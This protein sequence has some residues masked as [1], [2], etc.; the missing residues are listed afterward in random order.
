MAPSGRYWEDLSRY[1]LAEI[2][3]LDALWRS[4]A[5]DL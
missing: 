2:D 5:Q 3:A 4:V 1:D